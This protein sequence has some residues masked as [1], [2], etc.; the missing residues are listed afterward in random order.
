VTA[1]EVV[2]SRL[3]AVNET[4]ERIRDESADRKVIGESVGLL[5]STTSFEFAVAIV[6]FAKLLSP[7]DILTTA[8]QGPDATLDTVVSLS[9]AASQCLIELRDNLDTV[10]ANATE[11][12]HSSGI[13]SQFPNRWPCKISRRLDSGQN[14]TVLSASDEV[15][16]EMTEVVDTAL[17]DLKARFCDDAG[18][19]YKLVGKLMNAN[20]TTDELQVLIETLYPAFVDA[21]FAVAEFDV[22]R[23]I[24]AWTSAVSLQQRALLCP[25]CM[26][27]LRKLYRILITVPVTSANAERTFSKLAII[28]SKLRTTC[29]QERLEKLVLCS[30]ERDLVQKADVEKIVDRFSALTDNL[31][32]C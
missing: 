17:F 13:E 14:E 32:L 19:V 18:K 30:V 23:R 31:A 4:L 1:V 27:E 25:P 9:Q 12:A 24:A 29:G 28:N 6:F 21:E 8:I 2:R 3:S 16:R 20:T 15:K 26:N 7:L 5:A 22:V 11:L 10:L